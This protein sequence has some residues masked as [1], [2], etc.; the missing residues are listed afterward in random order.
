MTQNTPETYH[1]KAHELEQDLRSD[2]S[3]ADETLQGLLL[4]G[5]TQLLAQASQV[6]HLLSMQYLFASFSM[7]KYPEEFED[8]VPNADPNDPNQQKIN[9]MRLAQVEAIRRWDARVLFVA[10]QEMTH[11]AFVQ[12][13]YAIIG[14]EPYLFRPNF[15]V[16]PAEN[17]FAKPINL[18]RF[19]RHTLEV[20]RYW[21]KPDTV[22]L[23][24]PF[25]LEE[26]PAAIRKLA[27]EVPHPEKA[28]PVS[29]EEAR[30]AGLSYLK[31]I[32]EERRPRSEDM[33]SDY[34]ITVR[35]IEELYGYIKAF[36]VVLLEL[37]IIEGQNLDRVVNEH[38]GFNIQLDPVV[39]GKYT[40]Y[41]EEII[42]QIIEEGEGVGGV[43]PPLGSHFWV[44]QTLLDELSEIAAKSANAGLSFDPALPVVPNPS[45]ALNPEHHLV[46]LPGECGRPEDSPL[47]Q[48][49]NPVAVEAMTLF[50]QAYNVLVNMLYGFFNLY[51]ID[52]TTGIRPPEVNAFFRSSFYPFMTMVIRPLGE[53]VSRLPADA[54]YQ[55]DPGKRV[56]DATAGPNFFFSAS[57]V[58]GKEEDRI[59]SFKNLIHKEDFLTAFNQMV[60]LADKI[61]DD[62]A[63]RGYHMANYEAQNAR[64]FNVRFHYLAENFRRIALNFDAYWKGEMVA[65]IPSK[66]FYNFPDTF[67]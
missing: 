39:D 23:P 9:H 20:F 13:L 26:V 50:N 53:M 21:E 35:S 63:A 60:D 29:E 28:E 25:Q 34:G 47:T 7:K 16:P 14:Q 2:L 33:L 27:S 24:D 1:Q 48:V 37:R 40:Q 6:E 61:G 36:F 10:R 4:E 55:P 66:G 54:S 62:C 38:F 67:N 31:R 57:H 41:V 17:P 8:Y 42:K 64:D 52:Q 56:P 32:V 18:M 46:P 65:P 19:S 59:S 44:Y 12:N 30:F 43:P 58:F 11:L 51:S 49:T 22:Q 15:P 45:T 5:L 3:Q